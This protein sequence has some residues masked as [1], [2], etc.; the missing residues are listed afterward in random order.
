MPHI[1]GSLQESH[2]AVDRLLAR[3]VLADDAGKRAQHFRSLEKRLRAEMA[4]KEQELYPLVARGS[5]A[6]AFVVKVA[7]GDHLEIAL[8]LDR[9]ERTEAGSDAF[10]DQVLELEEAIDAHLQREREEILHFL[11]DSRA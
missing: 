8:I 1:A 4:F 7:L 10:L 2:R 6:A 11:D 3:I 9:L 5:G